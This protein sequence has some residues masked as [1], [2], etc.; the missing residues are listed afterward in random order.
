MFA[1]IGNTSQERNGD[2]YYEKRRLLYVPSQR[3][4]VEKNVR[5]LD[6]EGRPISID[7]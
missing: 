3:I 6:R 2:W 1:R 4:P 7:L 5:V